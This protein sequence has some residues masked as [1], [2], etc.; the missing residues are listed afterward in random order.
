MPPLDLFYTGAM[1]DRDRAIH[2][3][4]AAREA[5]WLDTA[6][7]GPEQDVLTRHLKEEVAHL[8]EIGVS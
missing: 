7:R 6:A 3:I 4:D 5:F 1:I 8:K 2:E